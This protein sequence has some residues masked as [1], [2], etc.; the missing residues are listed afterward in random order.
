MHNL[1]WFTDRIWTRIY[2]KKWSC[3]CAWC[4]DVAKNWLIIVDIF[5]AECLHMYQEIHIYQYKSIKK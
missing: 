3:K 1:K 5:H 2:R 4:A